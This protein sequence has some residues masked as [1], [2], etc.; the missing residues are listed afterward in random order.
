MNYE[1]PRVTD[2]GFIG[3]HTFTNT[4]QVPGVGPKGKDK[5]DLTCTPDKFSEP[6][7]GSP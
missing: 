2:H 1:T 4:G 7:C 3:D 5:N 6:S